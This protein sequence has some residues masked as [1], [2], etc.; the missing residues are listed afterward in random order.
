MKFL[1]GIFYLFF[2][3]FIL[4]IGLT[5]FGERF[6]FPSKEEIVQRINHESKYNLQF[7]TINNNG[8]KVGYTAIGDP[9]KQ[10]L[11]FVHGSPGSWN[12]FYMIM[13]SCMIII[14]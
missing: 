13:M 10:K 1:K 4:L 8:F 5:Y 7:K 6:F 11:I 14:I 3:I 9:S 2:V 12:N